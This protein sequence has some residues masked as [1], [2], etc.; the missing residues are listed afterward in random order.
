MYVSY[1]TVMDILIWGDAESVWTSWMLHIPT[2]VSFTPVQA[3]AG[4]IGFEGQRLQ[5]I[6]SSVSS[7]CPWLG[8]NYFLIDIKQ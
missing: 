5:K 2:G 7:L 6:V 4:H 8:A 3:T 1:L